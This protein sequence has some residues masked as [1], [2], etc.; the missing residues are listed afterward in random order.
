[1]KNTAARPKI[2]VT[3]DGRGVVGHAGTR[4]LADIAEVTGLAR[5]SARRWW[6]PDVGPVGTTRAGWPSTW[7]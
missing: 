6:L 5:G 2:T 3:A 7:R 4:L 1:V